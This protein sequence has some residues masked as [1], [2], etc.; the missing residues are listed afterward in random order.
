MTAEGS[1]MKLRG[2][3]LFCEDIRALTAFYRDVL[4]L[5][6]DDPQ[7]F[8]PDRFF[9]FRGENGAHL[10]LHSGTKPNGGRAKLLFDVDSVTDIY[11]RLRRAGRRVREPQREDGIVCYDFRDPEGNRIQVYG[12]YDAG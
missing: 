9:R 10:S 12:P 7:P 1:S 3:M 6:P 5:E 4:G 2:V 8:P 11:E